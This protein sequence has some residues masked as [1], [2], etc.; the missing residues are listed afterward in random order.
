MLRKFQT[1][2]VQ[3]PSNKNL[4]TKGIKFFAQGSANQ[5]VNLIEKRF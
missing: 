2:N 5:K 3:E 1:E 4:K